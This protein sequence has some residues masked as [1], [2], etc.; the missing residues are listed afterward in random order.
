MT[1]EFT[2]EEIRNLR[3]SDLLDYLRRVGWSRVSRY[4]DNASIYQH[5]DGRE[6]LV[7]D[8]EDLFDYVP[9]LR[10]A[11]TILARAH[12]KSAVRVYQDVVNQG[13][14]VIRIAAN[15]D[16]NDDGTIAPDAASDLFTGAKHL[17]EAAVKSALKNPEDVKEYWRDARFGQT[18]RGSYVVTMLSPP[19][20]LGVQI[21]LDK[22][23]IASTPARKVTNE[24][25]D[26]LCRTRSLVTGLRDDDGSAVERAAKLGISYQICESLGR[27]LNPF[28]SISCQVYESDILASR[29][30]ENDI[31]RFVQDDVEYLKLATDQLKAQERMAP[32]EASVHGYILRCERREDRDD[33]KVTLNVL[34]P[35]AKGVQTVHL[36]VSDGDY[37]QALQLHGQKLRVDARGELVHTAKS[38]WQLRNAEMRRSL[39]EDWEPRQSRG[40]Q[41]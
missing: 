4:G 27:V 26:A 36:S 11:L 16:A 29:C 38:T 6:L 32:A 25:K 34:M 37:K 2:D 23:D 12:D 35:D 13:R 8:R 18:E 15:N 9:V 30:Y 14:D 20:F 33:G 1:Y 3:L 10:E 22:S 41:E 17:W 21:A 39:S 19:V 24:L 5:E 28:G 7:P 40:A 31:A